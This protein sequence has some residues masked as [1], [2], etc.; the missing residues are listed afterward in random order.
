MWIWWV[1]PF[2]QKQG[3][4]KESKISLEPVK[5]GW[6][7]HDANQN[8]INGK[9]F[10][11][12]LYDIKILLSRSLEQKL[13]PKMVRQY[14][15]LNCIWGN[16][17]N[18]EKNNKC[19]GEIFIR[20][21]KNYA[22]KTDGNFQNS[23][24]TNKQIQNQHT[25]VTVCPTSWRRVRHVNATKSYLHFDRFAGEAILCS[26]FFCF[27]LMSYFFHKCRITSNSDIN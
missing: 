15:H 2:F 5:N 20:F 10:Q 18:S 8:Y 3:I 26:N 23:K 1:V 19:I 11:G 14:S 12:S 9:I 16:V 21:R 6:C 24:I 22:V 25:Y 4:T 17:L 7:H 27:L 13:Y